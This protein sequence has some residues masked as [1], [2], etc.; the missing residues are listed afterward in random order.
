[1]N[2]KSQVEIKCEKEDPAQI[3]VLEWIAGVMGLPH[4]MALKEEV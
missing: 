1:M 4:I 2:I 3:D